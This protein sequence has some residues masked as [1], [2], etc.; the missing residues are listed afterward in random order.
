MAAMCYKGGVIKYILEVIWMQHCIH[1][2]I[3]QGS[4][5]LIS[6]CE[7]QD[8]ATYGQIHYLQE[9]KVLKKLYAVK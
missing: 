8:R 6:L 7:M 1:C 4:D 2:G 5:T 9:K 3:N